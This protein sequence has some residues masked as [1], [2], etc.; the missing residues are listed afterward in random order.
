MYVCVHVYAY[1]R[2]DQAENSNL[3]YSRTRIVSHAHVCLCVYVHVRL[4]V[5]VRSQTRQ[6]IVI[7]SAVG[8]EVSQW[9]A[10]IAR[11]RVTKACRAVG[12]SV[13]VAEAQGPRDIRHA[14]AR[15]NVASLRYAQMSKETY[16]KAKETYKN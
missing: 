14:P 6:K 8:P 4:C 5:C 2:A 15:A 9:A 10:G 1:G 7:R 3:H 12:H 11:A 13:L 16:Y